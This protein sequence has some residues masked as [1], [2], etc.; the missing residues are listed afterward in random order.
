MNDNAETTATAA[1][2][3]S[4]PSKTCPNCNKAVPNAMRRCNGVK[5]GS[6][7]GYEW[8]TKK[9]PFAGATKVEFAALVKIIDL[10]RSGQALTKPRAEKPTTDS[11]F[12]AHDA[13]DEEKINALKTAARGWAEY[14]LGESLSTTTIKRL[15]EALE[16]PTSKPAEDEA[17]PAED[18]AKP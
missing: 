13:G 12:A 15:K 7:C 8:K 4:K 11:I 17:K 2:E 14:E 18:E 5:D 9:K 10:L 6:A 16:I 1:A 3:A